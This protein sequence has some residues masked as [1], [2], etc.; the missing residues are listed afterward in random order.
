MN[1][2]TEQEKTE[3]NLE[4]PSL[5]T[6]QQAEQSAMEDK[7]VDLISDHKSELSQT[8]NEPEEK[9]APQPVEIKRDEDFH[10]PPTVY[11]PPFQLPVVEEEVFSFVYDTEKPEPD[12]PLEEMNYAERDYYNTVLEMYEI[13]KQ[14]AMAE[15]KKKWLARKRQRQQAYIERLKKEEMER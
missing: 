5:V 13:D 9:E 15:A 1:T 3:S 10:L 6:T 12:K 8:Q 11:R 4:D 14:N 2:L 7:D